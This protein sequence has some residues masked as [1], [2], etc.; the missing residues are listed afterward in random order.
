[1]MQWV[2]TYRGRVWHVALAG[3][4]ILC[5]PEL[6]GSEFI[7]GKPPR[8]AIPCGPCYVAITEAHK[9]VAAATEAARQQALGAVEETTDGA[10]GMP[11]PLSEPR[12]GLNWADY[13]EDVGAPGGDGE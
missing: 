11:L 9:H 8:G 13:V 6:A 3:G 12:E 7:W 4:P 1:M 2:R 10:V 5:N